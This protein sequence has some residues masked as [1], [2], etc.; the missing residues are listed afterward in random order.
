MI[1]GVV[2]FAASISASELTLKWNKVV[3]VSSIDSVGHSCH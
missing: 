2:S 3:G 1:L